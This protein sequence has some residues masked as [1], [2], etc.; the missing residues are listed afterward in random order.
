MH[1]TRRDFLKRGS[2]SLPAAAAGAA[3]VKVSS[4]ENNDV[5]DDYIERAG[6]AVLEGMRA[7]KPLAHHVRRFATLLDVGLARLDSNGV[8]ARID[9]VIHSGVS[10]LPAAGAL[11]TRIRGDG[12]PITELE[13]STLYSR[14]VA[15][16]SEGQRAVA[17][18]TAHELNRGVVL[19]FSS[20]A[21]HLETLHASAPGGAPLVRVQS[22]FCFWA[23]WTLWYVSIVLIPIDPLLIPLWFSWAAA[24]SGGAVQVVC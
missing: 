13:F 18:H 15:H 4:A 16:T 7:G 3:L 21:A 5:L 17:T 14:L 9:Q 8:T 22:N 12:V 23:G 20:W 24:L 10:P 19:C 6:H 11:L 2:L 1:N